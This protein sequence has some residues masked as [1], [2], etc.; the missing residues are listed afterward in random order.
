MEASSS[1]DPAHNPLS[2]ESSSEGEYDGQLPQF[3][4]SE[5]SPIA[6]TSAPRTIMNRINKNGKKQI[7]FSSIKKKV[8]PKVGLDRKVDLSEKAKDKIM[9]RLSETSQVV[10]REDLS[11]MIETL[12]IDKDYLQGKKGLMGKAVQSMG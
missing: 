7:A 8:V 3:S 9:E 10:K 5:A 12:Q 2:L 11:T 4:D 6:S 1:T